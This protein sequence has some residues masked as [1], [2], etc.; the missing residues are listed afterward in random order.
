MESL[1]MAVHCDGRKKGGGQPLPDQVPREGRKLE[2]DA[3][4]RQ[5]C[6]EVPVDP[7]GLGD[8]Q[9]IQTDTGEGHH[10]EKESLEGHKLGWRLDSEDRCIL[11]KGEVALQSRPHPVG[12]VEGRAASSCQLMKDL[13]G[14]QGLC[15]SDRT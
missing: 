4:W 3:R 5:V 1:E 9:E 10:G 14:Q 15:P 11:W 6:Q 7:G 8:G 2:L 12:E 13:L